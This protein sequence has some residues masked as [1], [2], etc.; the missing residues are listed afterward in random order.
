MV[1]LSTLMVP[2]FIEILRSTAPTEALA[3]LDGE[4]AGL[5]SRF[6]RQRF[7]FAFSGVSRHFGKKTRVSVSPEA[8][9]A[10]QAAAP[11]LSL[12][13]WD[14]FR[15][16]RV[17]LLLV[18]AEQ[19]GETYRATLESV[20]GSAD[21]REQVAIFSAFP[22]LPEPEF[23][24]P[25][26][27]EGSRTNIVDVFDAI[28]LDNPFPAAHFPDEAWNQL[29]LKAIFISRPV[30]RIEGIDDRANAALALALSNLAHERWAAGRPVTPELWR[31][32]ARFLDDRIISDLHRVA[33]DPETGQREAVALIAGGENGHLLAD[34]R[35]TLSDLVEAAR[36]SDLTWNSL[37]ESLNPKS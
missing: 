37:G 32:C 11:G 23:L 21:L 2:L 26:A 36:A 16:A 5:R 22:L 12:A 33:Q 34:L 6:D 17:A 4:I 10:V 35:E 15:L 27:R 28:A 1:Q 3:W 7:Y 18:L 29:V 8:F 13:G 20:L 30:Y 9:S 24:V 19:Q 14:E 25:L 31:S